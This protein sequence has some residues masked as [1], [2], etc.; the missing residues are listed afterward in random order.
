MRAAVTV[1]H[2]GFRGG[3][4]FFSHSVY[5]QSGAHTLTTENAVRTLDYDLAVDVIDLVG[6]RG[7]RRDLSQ[8]ISGTLH[9]AYE[10]KATFERGDLYRERDI[11]RAVTIVTEDGE[12]TITVNG[13]PFAG[14]VQTGNVA[15]S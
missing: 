14:N 12:A 5:S 15:T 10:A 13:E 6:P 7:S 2:L 3:A 9:G 8:K 1:P 11:D 4:R